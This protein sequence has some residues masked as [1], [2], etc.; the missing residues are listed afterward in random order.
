[1]HS[2]RLF[3]L[4]LLTMTPASTILAQTE[5]PVLAALVETTAPA[6]GNAWPSP[7]VPRSANPDPPEREI[8]ITWSD[9]AASGS[10]S[11]GSLGMSYGRY[12]AKNMA[13]EAAVDF[14]RDT[15]PYALSSI[16]LRT[17]PRDFD[18]PFSGSVGL[19][20]ASAGI[21]GV[22][23]PKGLGFI[24][25][26]GGQVRFTSSLAFRLDAQLLLFRNDALAG[27]VLVST[28]IGLD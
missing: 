28:L 12:L 11:S 10:S 3:V 2:R 5:H 14:G 9:W 26:G 19:A 25:G 23:G 24:L 6:A 22:N 1:M 18:L 4:A 15:R 27:R 17:V 20:F 8:G 7:P 13:V 16:V 21:P